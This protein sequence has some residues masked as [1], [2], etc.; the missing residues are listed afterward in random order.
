VSPLVKL[1]IACLQGESLEIQGLLALE[2]AVT[3]DFSRPSA[4]RSCNPVA[5]SRILRTFVIS[6]SQ[7]N[8]NPK[9]V[10]PR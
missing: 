3:M 10:D 2:L 9:L 5:L 7:K 4:L 6:I 1:L 8:V